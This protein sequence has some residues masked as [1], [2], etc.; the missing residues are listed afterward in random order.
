MRKTFVVTCFDV[1]FKK[2]IGFVSDSNSFVRSIKHG[3]IKSEG[4]LFILFFLFTFQHSQAQFPY[5]AVE[6]WNSIVS[7]TCSPWMSNPAVLTGTSPNTIGV[8]ANGATVEGTF[9]GSYSNGSG[10]DAY[11]IT[12]FH[13]TAYEIRLRLS[14]GTLT[15]PIRYEICQNINVGGWS[16]NYTRCSGGTGSYG[17]SLWYVPIDFVNFDIPNGLSVVGSRVNLLTS[18]GD[19]DLSKF[20]ITSNASTSPSSQTTSPP[21]PDLSPNSQPTNATF[22]AE[23]ITKLTLSG[24]TAPSSGAGGYVIYV[25]STN[26]FTAPS[27]GDLPSADTSWNDAGQ[28]SIY[29]GTTIPTNLQVTGLNP[30]TTYYFHI[31]AYNNCSGINYYES[32][33]LNANDTT[34]F[35]IP[36]RHGKH[37]LSGNEENMTFGRN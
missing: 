4:V 37:F 22:S 26:S 20:V 32:T 18:V 23:G 25:N 14:N 12:S 33:G 17:T 29:R 35:L 30:A 16:V 28:Q 7:S 31:Y 21:P 24:F 13:P 11:I 3:F 27:D 9:A 19:A 10:I 8:N 6:G 1:I 5:T 34:G 15:P 2:S 36:M